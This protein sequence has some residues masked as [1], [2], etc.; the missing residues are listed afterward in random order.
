MPKCLA[1]AAEE[2]AASPEGNGQFVK[3]PSTW[4]NGEC[5][6]DERVAWKSN[7]QSGSNGRQFEKIELPLLGGLGMTDQ[8][9]NEW[10]RYRGDC[11]GGFTEWLAKGRDYTERATVLRRWQEA[12]S[13]V[14]LQDAKAASSAIMRGHRRNRIRKPSEG[15]PP[16]KAAMANG[17]RSNGELSTVMRSSTA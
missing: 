12:L 4:L 11:V 9:F 13:D 7:Q 15:N 6:D 5:W 3:M 8:E 1:A 2:Y 17:P 10:I 14:S 16:R